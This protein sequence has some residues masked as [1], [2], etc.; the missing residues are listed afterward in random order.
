MQIKESHA[1]IMLLSIVFFSTVLKS[2]KVIIPKNTITIIEQGQTPIYSNDFPAES[3][4]EMNIG[5][6]KDT[7]GQMVNNIERSTGIKWMKRYR[8]GIR[9][10][11]HP[12]K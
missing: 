1:T 4:A 10:E 3:K 12:P 2:K 9:F 8:S 7:S 11:F 5:T 6:F